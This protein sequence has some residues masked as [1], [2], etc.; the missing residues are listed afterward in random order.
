VRDD[1]IDFVFASYMQSADF[2]KQVGS[3]WLHDDTYL[4]VAHATIAAA[5]RR[6]GL[7]ANPVFYENY[8]LNLF[9]Y[10]KDNNGVIYEGDDYVEQWFIFHQS[11]K[12]KALEIR[13]GSNLATQRLGRLTSAAPGAL[14]LALEKIVAEDIKVPNEEVANQTSLAAEVLDFRIPASDRIVSL[15]DNEQTELE[16]ASS[17]LIEVV[18]QANGIDGDPTFRQ[19]V[20]GQLKAGRELIRAQIFN[21][22][23]M[24]FIV[25]ETLRNL[26]SRYEAHV[27][28][29]AAAT[30]IELLVKHL[31]GGS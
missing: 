20:L 29:A 1:Y 19:I 31:V 16:A 25:M 28:G 15:S 22:Q 13:I 9:E 5:F 21:A 12:N 27:I 14:R 8:F 30:L 7:E 18:E 4:D 10:L 17:E 26:K 2:D 24:H 6:H 11:N 3:D 23:I